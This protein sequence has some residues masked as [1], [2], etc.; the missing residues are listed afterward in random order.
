MDVSIERRLGARAFVAGWGIEVGRAYPNIT[1]GEGFSARLIQAPAK[2]LPLGECIR[3]YAA[4][5]FDDDS[6]F[7]AGW[8]GQCVSGTAPWSCLRMGCTA[9]GSVRERFRLL[10][11]VSPRD[12]RCPW[13]SHIA[14][15]FC[16]CVADSDSPTDRFCTTP[17]TPGGGAPCFDGGE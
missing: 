7:V 8:R 10:L 1:T 15:A 2:I 16:V 3:Q 12:S 9:A 4:L 17:V 6:D 13:L 5:G 11:C 14:F